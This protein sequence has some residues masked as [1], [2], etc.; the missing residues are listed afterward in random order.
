MSGK[1]SKSIFEIR[2]KINSARNSNVC[3]GNPDICSMY[4][5][6]IHGM[7]KGVYKE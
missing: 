1:I 5:D 4:N 7:V 3:K 6:S 2:D